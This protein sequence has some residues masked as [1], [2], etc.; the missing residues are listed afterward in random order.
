MV[1][2]LAT[3]LVT[4]I[5][6]VSDHGRRIPDPA[7]ADCSDRE[8]DLDGLNSGISAV[9]VAGDVVLAALLPGS[10]A[11]LQAAVQSLPSAEPSRRPHS[12]SVRSLP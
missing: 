8:P 11:T 9:T 10:A 1:C 7:Y 6:N 3:A 2:R 12:G 4:S 5:S